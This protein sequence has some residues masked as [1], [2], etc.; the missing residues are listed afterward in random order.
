MIFS[1]FVQKLEWYF[2]TFYQKN[3]HVLS[4]ILTN[5]SRFFMFYSRSWMM[6]YY[7]LLKNIHVL[8]MILMNFSRF[9]RFFTL[10]SSTY[11]FL[12]VTLLRAWAKRVAELL[13]AEKTP[14]TYSLCNSTREVLYYVWRTYSRLFQE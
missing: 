9:S 8:S 7:I 2:I 5:S 6:F 10:F 4:M 1:C 12:Q 11:S 13:F 14:R 3:I